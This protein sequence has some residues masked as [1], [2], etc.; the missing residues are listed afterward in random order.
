MASYRRVLSTSTCAPGQLRVGGKAA[1]ESGK[2]ARESGL[3]GGK[4]PPR[5]QGRRPGKAASSESGRAARE[6]G[7]LG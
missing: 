3:L 7:L 2:A 5:S 1:S 6:S 4:W